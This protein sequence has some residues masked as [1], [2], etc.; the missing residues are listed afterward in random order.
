MLLHLLHANTLQRLTD[1]QTYGGEY[2]VI[3]MLKTLTDGIFAADLEEDVNSYRQNLQVEYVDMLVAAMSRE[4]N[5]HNIRAA[6]FAQLLDLAEAIKSK[7]R[8]SDFASLSSATQAHSRYLEFILR[9]ALAV[10][11]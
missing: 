10:D 11:D 1:T 9:K 2:S 7:I 4:A 6:L 3:E 5:G 8:G